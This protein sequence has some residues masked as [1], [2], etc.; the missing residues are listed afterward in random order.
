MTESWG[1][2]LA[3][4]FL[5]REQ[6]SKSLHFGIFQTHIS[7]K[8][9]FSPHPRQL[10]VPPKPLPAPRVGGCSGRQADTQPFPGSLPSLQGQ[11]HVLRTQQWEFGVLICNPTMTPGLQGE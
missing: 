3:L 4:S 7:V 10:Q 2:I 8:V 11:D 6:C 5:K 9:V 1:V